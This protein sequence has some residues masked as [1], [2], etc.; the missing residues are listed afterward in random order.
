MG[1]G[2]T[3]RDTGAYA[4]TK[5]K[6]RHKAQSHKTGSEREVL[7]QSFIERMCCCWR[8][9]KKYSAWI[10][11]QIKVLFKVLNN[12]W[13]SRGPKPPKKTR[14]WACRGG[15][16]HTSSGRVSPSQRS[17]YRPRIEKEGRSGGLEKKPKSRK[18]KKSQDISGWADKK[19][20]V[21]K[22]PAWRKFGSEI[23]TGGRDSARLAGWV[24][25]GMRVK[26]QRRGL[27]PQ[28]RVENHALL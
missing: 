24:V 21:R 25:R 11:V 28:P 8:E 16:L 1:N 27:A 3:W 15:L 19:K 23:G 13:Q 17:G 10:R 6:T 7:S 26:L 22:T 12:V 9:K 14:V 2:G 18:A 20:F 4:I 5:L